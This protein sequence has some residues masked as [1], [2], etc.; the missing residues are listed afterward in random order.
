MCVKLFHFFD[1][2]NGRSKVQFEIELSSFLAIAILSSFTFVPWDRVEMFSEKYVLKYN[3][4]CK[5]SGR[6]SLTVFS[7]NGMKE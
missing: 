2:I 5:E 7:Q 3:V 4:K 1:K 6:Q